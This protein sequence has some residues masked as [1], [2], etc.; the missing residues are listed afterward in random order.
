MDGHRSP[1][2]EPT[3][4][5]V[6]FPPLALRQ[7]ANASGAKVYQASVLEQRRRRAG[8]WL[9]AAWMVLA[10]IVAAAQL[11]VAIVHHQIFGTLSSMAFVVV[12]SLPLLRMGEI[13]GAVR[14][15]MAALKRMR[16]P[17]RSAS[18]EVHSPAFDWK[19]RANQSID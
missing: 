4:K 18:A 10:W 1:Q 7:K 12:V 17:R 9:D 3:G 6:K 14:G 11:S 15:A 16:T 8:K 2:V 5:V 13:L 19:K